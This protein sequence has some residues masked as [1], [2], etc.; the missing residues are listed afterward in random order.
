MAALPRRRPQLGGA[1]DVGRLV[2]AGTAVGLDDD[3]RAAYDAPFPTPASKAGVLAFP[4]Q[5]PTEPEH[6]NAA[7]DAARA[8]GA[9]QLAQAGARRLGSGGHRAAAGASRS[10]SSS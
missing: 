4:E 2:A 1:L 8:R 10:A 7:A 5:V 9:A 3:V 6:P